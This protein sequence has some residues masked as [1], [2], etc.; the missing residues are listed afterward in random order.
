MG[1]DGLL[2]LPHP[3][4]ERDGPSTPLR[5]TEAVEFFIPDIH[6]R[7]RI[8]RDH[9]DLAGQDVLIL[10][11]ESGPLPLIERRL[12]RLDNGIDPWVAVEHEVLAPGLDLRGVIPVRLSARIRYGLQAKDG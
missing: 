7:Q 4:E 6:S 1:L 11:K 3:L 12:G 5:H 10:E 9:G 2:L 8:E